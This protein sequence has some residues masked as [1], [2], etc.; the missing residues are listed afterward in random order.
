MFVADTMINK[1]IDKE[2]L[3]DITRLTKGAVEYYSFDP[4]IAM[5]SYSNFGSEE[6]AGESSPKMVSEAVAQL[7]ELYPEL[8]VDGEM[9]VDIALNK[10]KR[11]RIYPFNKL[12]GKDVNTLIFPSLNAATLTHETFLHLSKGEAI[13]PIQI[14]LNKPVHFISVESPVREI[15]NLATIASIDA[16]IAMKAGNCRLDKEE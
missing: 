16:A 8:C 5:L 2:T 12:R 1:H 6:G 11:D 10:E 13:G 7:H 15:F 3:I 9:Q 4:V 14:C